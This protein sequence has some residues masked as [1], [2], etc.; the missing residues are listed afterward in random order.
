MAGQT[1]ATCDVT[2]PALIRKGAED[3]ERIYLGL[4]APAKTEI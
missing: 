1:P 4:V 2:F 3:I